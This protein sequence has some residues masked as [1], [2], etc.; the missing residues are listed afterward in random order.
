MPAGVL[1]YLPCWCG[2][3]GGRARDRGRGGALGQST[4]VSQAVLDGALWGL[5]WALG[6]RETPRDARRPVHSREPVVSPPRVGHSGAGFLLA[7]DTIK[8]VGDNGTRPMMERS[9]WRGHG[10]PPRT[11]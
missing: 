3:A 2:F 9:Q 6:G 4:G 11:A 7:L 10:E 1:S 5:I 8:A